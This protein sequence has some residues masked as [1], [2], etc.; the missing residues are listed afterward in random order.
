MGNLDLYNKYRKVPNEAKKT[1]QAGKLK[2][3]TD[4]NPMW[5]IKMLTEE[6]GICGIGWYTEILNRWIEKGPDGKEAAFVEIA[7]YIKADGEWSKPI[8]GVGGSA[9][10][11][12]FKGQ[13]E[14]SDEAF[15]MAYTDAIS[16]ACKALG[17]GADVYFDKDRTKYN[18]YD[19]EAENGSKQVICPI[20]NTEIKAV[21]N[22]GKTFT[23]EF[24]LNKYKMCGECYKKSKEVSS[25]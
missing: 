22:N 24:I 23:P 5:R 2:G 21:V 16:I 4:I 9:F 18:Q 19:N 25:E 8:I 1:I 7:L 13:L 15:K 10:V 6:F 11:N 14:T 3:F 17:M 20:C 12:I